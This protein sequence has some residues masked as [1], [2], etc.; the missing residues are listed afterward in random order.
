VPAPAV[1]VPWQANAPVYLAAI[2]LFVLS[3]WLVRRQLP[4]VRVSGVLRGGESG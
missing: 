1:V 2:V 4:D 3:V